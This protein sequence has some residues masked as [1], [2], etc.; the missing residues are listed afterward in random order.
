MAHATA[1]V[2]PLRSLTTTLHT[3]QQLPQKTTESCQRLLHFLQSIPN[4]VDLLTTFP[5]EL[6]DAQWDLFSGLLACM[7]LP[8]LQQTTR[9]I[10]QALC[11]LIPPRE[12]L[13]I[14]KAA[15][16]NTYDMNIRLL[17]SVEIRNALNRTE[18]KRARPMDDYLSM[19]RRYIQHPLLSTE[20]IG[21]NNIDEDED[22]DEDSTPWQERLTNIPKTYE[23]RV[24]LS[25]VHAHDIL[26]H[27][28]TTPGS[29]VK[30]SHREEEICGLR[31]AS[32]NF[33]CFTLEDYST[34]ALAPQ[35]NMHG[36]R[37][38]SKQ[39]QQQQRR[40]RRWRAIH[41]RSN[42]EDEGG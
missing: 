17:V 25:M 24:R 28:N 12:L 21:Q 34:I 8:T 31:A 2:S 42:H 4:P 36:C 9:P 6:G 1:K 32:V 39:Q 40:Q 15:L 27:L 7:E 18:R 11:A 33:A 3:F 35:P 41:A 20:T 5:T 23:D 13:L 22:E 26:S 14:A 38:P 37:V 29:K 30:E 19:V 10:L 16:V